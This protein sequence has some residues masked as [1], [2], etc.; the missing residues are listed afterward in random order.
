M[1]STLPSA[2]DKIM[3]K[4]VQTFAMHNDKPPWLAHLPG[5]ISRVGKKFVSDVDGMEVVGVLDDMLVNGT[6][7]TI[8]DYKTSRTPYTQ[9]NAEKYYQLQMDAYALLCER[10]NMGA[11]KE[12]LLVFFTPSV[13]DGMDNHPAQAG[14]MF[15]VTIIK[16]ATSPQRAIDTIG[17]VQKVV[18]LDRAPE[19]AADCRWCNW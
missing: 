15:D 9:A 2:L 12:A 3:Q 1:F 14:F 18:E 5:T 4:E 16:L 19:A 7:H 10:H 17:E 6:E 11:I 8:I 13:T